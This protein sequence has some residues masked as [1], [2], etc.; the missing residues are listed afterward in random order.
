MTVAGVSMRQMLEAGVHFGHQTRRWNPRM[1][2]FIYTE[3]HGIHIIDLGQTVK[4][5][6]TALDRVRETA[7]S[8]QKV[9]FVG[10]KK[11]ARDVVKSEAER[12][13]QPYVVNR[14]LGGTLT[15]WVTITRR[16]DYLTQMES[17]IVSGE[18]QHLS[19]R[20]RMGIFKEYSRLERTLGGLR[21]LNRPPGLIFI[22][23]PGME[24][25]AVTEANRLSIPIAALCDTDANPDLIEYPIPGNDDAIRSIQLMTARIADAVLEG[26]AA[27]GIELAQNVVSAVDVQAMA[28]ELQSETRTEPQA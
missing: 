20:E 9:L 14:W 12:C 7:A 13:G 17:R 3:R 11:Q 25:I 27:G 15:N 6:E 19:K 4:R 2:P 1:R 26:L 23:D 16:I 8:G 18:D 5:M 24:E 10:T 28:A 21:T 22:V